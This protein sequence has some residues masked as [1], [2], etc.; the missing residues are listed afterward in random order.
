MFDSEHIKNDSYFAIPNRLFRSLIVEV[1]HV[2][3]NDR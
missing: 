1:L 2:S 3:V